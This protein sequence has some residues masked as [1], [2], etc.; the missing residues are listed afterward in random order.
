M[1]PST[2]K[3]VWNNPLGNSWWSGG[4]ESCF[5]LRVQVSPLVTELD[6]MSRGKENPVAKADF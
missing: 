4:Y 3:Y 1:N 6:P 2:G 5:L